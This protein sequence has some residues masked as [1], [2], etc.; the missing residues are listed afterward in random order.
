MGAL[1]KGKTGHVTSSA[2]RDFSGKEACHF[3]EKLL[4]GQGELSGS[5]FSMQ[6]FLNAGDA[7]SLHGGELPWRVA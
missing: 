7:E 5:T 2:Q 6:G 4:N 1:Q 3:L